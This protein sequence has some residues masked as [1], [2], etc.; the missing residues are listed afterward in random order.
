MKT[1]YL[2]FLSLIFALGSVAAQNTVT[3]KTGENLNTKAAELTTIF[4]KIM[5]L[6]GVSQMKNFELTSSFL[7][8]KPQ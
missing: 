1:T 3:V 4:Q 7:E 8:C 6:E 5:I 2:L